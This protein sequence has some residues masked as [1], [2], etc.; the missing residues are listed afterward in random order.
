MAD[1]RCRTTA[2]MA[3]TNTEPLRGFSGRTEPWSSRRKVSQANGTEQ[4]ITFHF[5]VEDDACGASSEKN[6]REPRCRGPARQDGP[7]TTR[8]AVEGR[9]PNERS[10]AG[11]PVAQHRDRSNRTRVGDVNEFGDNPFG[12]NYCGA[13]IGNSRRVAR[14]LRSGSNLSLSTASTIP[15]MRRLSECPTEHAAT[16]AATD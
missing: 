1:V 4:R 8:N 5:P 6:N 16:D 10:E 2:W 12:R 14:F 13:S 3:A 15:K 9:Q 11:V 7:G